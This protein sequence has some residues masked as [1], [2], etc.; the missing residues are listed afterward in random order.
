MYSHVKKEH[1][2]RRRVQ[3]LQCKDNFPNTRLFYKHYHKDHYKQNKT[4]ICDYCYK[5]FAQYRTIEQHIF[6]NHTT[7]PC[8]ECPQTFKKPYLLKQHYELK[9]RVSRTEASYCVECDR[10]FDNVPQFQN[11]IKTAVAHQ[12]DR[13]SR[14]PSTARRID[15]KTNKP[16]VRPSH[17]PCQCLACPNVYSKRQTM[18][19]HYNKVHLG[20]TKYCCTI[21]D[22]MFINNTKLQD[23]MKY[24][25]EGQV[26]ERKEICS[27]CGRGF[28]EKKILRNHMRTHTGERPFQCPHCDSKFTQKTAMVTHV[29]K[30]HMKV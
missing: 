30:I 5:R 10:Q 19:N 7:H 29:K 20:K 4:F 26:K 11:H 13:K 23:H 16:Y 1:T 18:M 15:G 6:K 2:S 14:T 24:N 28:T 3:C 8:S 21:C 9:H 27:I 22:K 17:R 25:H 12:E